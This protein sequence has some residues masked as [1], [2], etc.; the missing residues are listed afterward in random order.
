MPTKTITV[1]AA[2]NKRICDG[3]IWKVHKCIEYGSLREIEVIHYYDRALKSETTSLERCASCWGIS[4][5][6]K[7]VGKKIGDK[8]QI[9][10]NLVP[11]TYLIIE[12][13]G[14]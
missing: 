7:L 10:Y 4:N 8:V 2:C 12:K 13:I 1:C 5:I 11:C 14:D 3:S 9:Y 6:R